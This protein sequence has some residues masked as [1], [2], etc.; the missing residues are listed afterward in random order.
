MGTVLVFSPDCPRAALATTA[1]WPVSWDQAICAVMV[2]C[3]STHRVRSD[4]RG[5]R[6]YAFRVGL[7]CT[8][9]DN[10]AS[11]DSFLCYYLGLGFAA[12]LLYADDLEDEVVEVARRYPAERVLLCLHDPTLREEWRRLPSW[13][14]Q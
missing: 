6:K 2:S 14:R 3:C 5:H 7:V 1:P 13:G 9:R 8:M 11:L 10:A 12:M 4:H